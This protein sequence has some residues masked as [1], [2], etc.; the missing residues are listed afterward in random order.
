M[1]Q[2]IILDCDPGHDD[3]V[4][5]LLALASPELEVLGVTVTHGN[6]GLSRTLRNALVVRELAGSRVPVFAGAD[7]PL[8]RDR[9]SA[10][11]VHGDSG[12]AGPDLPEPSG[13][14]EPTRAADFIVDAALARPGELSVVAVGPLTN[15]ALALRLEPRLAGALR[16]VVVMG[17]SVDTGNTT[18]GAEFNILA[19][20]HAAAIV[21]SC[22][23]PL[24]MFGLNLTHQARAT[25]ERVRRFRALGT[26]VGLVTAELLEFFREHHRRRYGWDGA[27]LHDPCAVAHLLRPQLFRA[28]EMHVEVDTTTG[29]SLGRTVCDVWSV[30]GREPNAR[31]ALEVDADGFFDLLVERLAAYR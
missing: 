4:A 1:P 11:D 14:P 26:R 18:P 22:G 20:P 25:P 30:T 12:L 28:R 6:V 24:T 23:A 21:F 16:E 15:L 27:P 31:V 7:R 3:A 17:G 9:I 2:P 8:L 13:A 5:M 10:E 19:D 29:P